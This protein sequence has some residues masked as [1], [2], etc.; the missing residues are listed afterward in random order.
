MKIKNLIAIAAVSMCFV[1]CDDTT[2]GIGTSLINGADHLNVSSASFTVTSRSVKADSV[3]S[4]NTTAYIGKVRDPETGSYVTGNSMLQFHIQ[5]DYSFPDKENIVS[6]INGD[7]VRGVVRADSCELHLYFTQW[8]GDSL[9]TMRM[10]VAEMGRPM[11]ENVDYYSN[12]D[13]EEHGYLRNDG[14]Q[15][16]AD[17]VYTIE[18]LSRSASERNNSNYMS[19]ITIRLN[20]PYTDKD[21]NTYNNL[22]TYLMSKYYEDASNYKNSYNFIHRVFPGVYIKSIGGLGS[23]TYVTLSAID[24]YFHYYDAE[25]DTVQSGVSVF[26]GTDEVLQTTHITNDDASIE[27]LVSDNTCTYLKTP[28]GIF[29]ELTLPV[30]EI[31]NGHE[32]DSINQAKLVLN[33][34]NNSSTSKYS[35]DV[36]RTLLLIPKDSLKSFFANRD[37]ADYKT[38]FLASWGYSSSSSSSSYANSYTFHN[39]GGLISAMYRCDRSSA[40]WNK[41]IVVPVNTQYSTQSTTSVLAEVTHNMGL[42]STRLIGGSENPN[43]PIKIDIIYTKFSE[44]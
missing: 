14:H 23:M 1:A 31:M 2:D 44:Q 27:R 20:S 6:I 3:L 9:A 38:S 36:P 42:T 21:G 5:E 40:D 15:L 18:D 33:R 11:E 34:I 32:N 41:A 28:A 39:I 8:Y 26:S 24:I 16:T 37:I 25:N 30:E 12:Y 22:G 13:P 19:N 35:L 17:K 10:R 29:T 43:D 7:S 4:R